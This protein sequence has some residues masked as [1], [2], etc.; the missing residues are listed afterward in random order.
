MNRHTTISRRNQMRTHFWITL[1][2]TAGGSLLLSA[3][4]ASA[5]IITGESASSPNPTVRD[6]N[7]VVNNVGITIITND[8]VTNGQITHSAQQDIASQAGNWYVLD[9]SAAPA[10]GS[11]YIQ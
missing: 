11:R 3:L 9:A 10:D 8:L 2:A 5:A 6:P 7:G 4:P 1:L